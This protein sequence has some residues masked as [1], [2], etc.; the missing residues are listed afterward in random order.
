MVEVSPASVARF[1]DVRVLLE[2][3]FATIGEA[4]PG[5]EGYDRIRAA[6]G[7]GEIEFHV[8]RDGG[9]PVGLISLTMGFSTYRAAPFALLEDL[10][11]ERSHRRRGIARRLIEAATAAATARGCGSLLAGV[12]ATDLAMWGHL[13]FRRIGQLVARDLPA[14]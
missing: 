4:D 3:F 11:V 8:A 2:R 13:G 9:V 12:G 5:A 6:A 14:P 10:F 1:D 7:R